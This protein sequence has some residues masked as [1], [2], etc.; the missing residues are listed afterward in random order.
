MRDVRDR[1]THVKDDIKVTL[2]EVPYVSNSG[3]QHCK[4]NRYNVS[5]IFVG[6]DTLL[7]TGK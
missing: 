2:I 4:E 5:A 3:P 1:H 7:Q 6:F